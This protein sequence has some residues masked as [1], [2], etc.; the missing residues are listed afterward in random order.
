MVSIAVAA[1]LWGTWP[2]YTRA[3]G[4]TGVAIGF[5]ALLVMALP[6]PF[7]FRRAHFADRGAVLALG[8]VAL[9]DAANVVLYFAA[10]DRGPVVVAV[11]SHYLAPTLVALLAPSLLAERS[12]PRALWASPVVLIGLALVLN[13]G[14]AVEGWGT[15]ALLGG[16]S[17]F[18][19]AVVVLGSRRAART[20][21]PVAVMSLHAAVSAL[22]L[23]AVFGREAVPTR[24]DGAFAVVLFGCL[25]NGL[26]AAVL[27]N[28]S[29]TRLEAPLVSLFTYLEPLTAAVLGVVLLGDPF[30]FSGA[31]GVSLVIV[32]GAWAALGNRPAGSQ[33]SVPS[34]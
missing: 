26:G 30:G 33:I 1:M 4:P 18:F 10:L 34:P 7:S 21:T 28:W 20:F 8:L 14:S 17:A 32:S 9:A 15:T 22:L 19:Y 12:S 6:A 29:L 31:L 11:L 5:L 27:F 3:G 16:G 24:V 2:L 23:L 25:V 13:Q